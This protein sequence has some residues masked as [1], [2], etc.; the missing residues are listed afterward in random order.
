MIWLPVNR[1]PRCRGGRRNDSATRIGVAVRRPSVS[2]VGRRINLHHLGIDR[3]CSW[4]VLVGD[5]RGGLFLGEDAGHCVLASN[6]LGSGHG[7]FHCG[8]SSVAT[9][10]LD[11][12]QPATPSPAGENSASPRASAASSSLSGARLWRLVRQCSA[13]VWLRPRLLRSHAPPLDILR[14]RP[15]SS[16]DRAVVF[17]TRGAYTLCSQMLGATATFYLSAQRCKA[18]A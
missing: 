8:P 17:L 4:P 5:A 18:D 16:E 6:D 1:Q 13:A 14:P 3:T 9:R 12:R 11:R 10:E 2:L 15:R 7:V